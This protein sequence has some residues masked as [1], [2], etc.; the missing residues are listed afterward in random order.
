[1]SFN[2]GTVDRVIRIVLGIGLIV[3]AYFHIVTG[4]LA[5]V[6]YVVA[7]IAL[8]T[9]L[10]RFCPAWALFGINTSTTRTLK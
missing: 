6:A 1:M 3:L 7:A 10:I 2:V 9:G 8:V 5:I 4:T